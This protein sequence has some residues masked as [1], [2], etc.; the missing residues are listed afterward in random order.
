MSTGV[1]PIGVARI[2]FQAQFE[3]AGAVG[4][5]GSGFKKRLPTGAILY[6]PK[7]MLNM[8]WVGDEKSHSPIF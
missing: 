1:V 4:I 7:I 6:I 5:A 3:E 2:W 8:K